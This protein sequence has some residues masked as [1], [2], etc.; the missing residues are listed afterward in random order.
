MARPP[1]WR[2]VCDICLLIMIISFWPRPSIGHPSKT[3]TYIHLYVHT[4]IHAYIHL[5]SPSIFISKFVPSLLFI[6]YQIPNLTHVP[7]YCRMDKRRLFNCRSIVFSPLGLPID[8]REKLKAPLL[9]AERWI[10]LFI[11]IFNFFVYLF[12]YLF[13]YL[14]ACSFLFAFW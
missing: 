6:F 1:C 14:L 10:S 11:Y 3:H 4:C 5:T 12:I 9:L 13:T 8:L 7:L 2:S